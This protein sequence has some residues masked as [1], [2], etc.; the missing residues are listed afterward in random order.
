[1]PHD[2]G[3]SR[4]LQVATPTASPSARALGGSQ[5]TG[6]SFAESLAKA[7]DG[8]SLTFSAHAASRLAS[9]NIRFSADEM[10][11]VQQATDL[12][13]RK[14]SRDALLMMDDLGLIVNV[15]NRTVLTALDLGALSDGVV[16][17]IDST[18]VVRP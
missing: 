12:A 8:Q 6:N 1:M 15:K 3:L 4:L 2:A 10:A 18:V 14:G 11:R 9:R 5:A 7:S 17:N 16:T 13:A